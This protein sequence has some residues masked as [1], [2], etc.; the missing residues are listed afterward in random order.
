MRR[1]AVRRIIRKPPTTII[2]D[3][4]MFKLKFLRGGAD[5]SPHLQRLGAMD[6]TEMSLKLPRM[7]LEKITDARPVCQFW[8]RGKCIKGSKC[9]SSSYT[10]TSYAFLLASQFLFLLRV[11]CL[12]CSYFLR[13][14]NSSTYVVR[15]GS[16]FLHGVVV[17]LPDSR[18]IIVVE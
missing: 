3:G 18:E 4:N 6:S 11:S 5:G 14:L 10:T 7:I 15:L 2:D 12:L 16:Y 17:A 13:V 1:R 8:R 9:N